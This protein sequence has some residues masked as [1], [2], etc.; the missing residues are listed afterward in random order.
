[1]KQNQVRVLSAPL[2]LVPPSSEVGTT[3]GCGN[4]QLAGVSSLP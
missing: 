3:V 1:M 2:P 4:A